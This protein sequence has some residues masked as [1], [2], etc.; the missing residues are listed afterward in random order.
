MG[1]LFGIAWHLLVHGKKITLMWLFKFFYLIM[2]NF[3]LASFAG[4]FSDREDFVR[5]IIILAASIKS[6]GVGSV[7]CRRSQ[8][9]GE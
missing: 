8:I 4:V 3:S 1:F 9:T 6:V 2:S 5:I 7:P